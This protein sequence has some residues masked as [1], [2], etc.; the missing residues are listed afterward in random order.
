[1]NIDKLKRLVDELGNECDSVEKCNQCPMYPTCE[2]MLKA[3]LST[4]CTSLVI[5]IKAYEYL[6][7]TSWSE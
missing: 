5:S 1:M 4:V 2:T 6:K 7:N 3:P